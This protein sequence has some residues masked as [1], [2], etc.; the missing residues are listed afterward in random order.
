MISNETRLKLRLA[1][2]GKPGNNLGN[3]HSEETKEKMRK[4]RISYYKK[5]GGM[6]DKTKELLRKI[7][8]EKGSGLWMKGKIWIRDQKH[9]AWKG[10]N[11]SLAALHTWVRRRKLKPSVCEH[12]NKVPPV[13]LAN[14]SQKYKRD[15]SDFL[16]LCRRCHMIQD[17]RIKEI[18]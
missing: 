10:D 4:A 18:V 12:C 17:G 8:I 14:V 1:K 2:L 16:W 9:H 11:V 7:A 3:K 5:N 15:V 13:D 6:S